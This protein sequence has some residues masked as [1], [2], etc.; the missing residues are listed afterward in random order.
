MKTKHC[1]FLLLPV[2]TLLPISVLAVTPKI[3]IG[4]SHALLLKNDGS[5]WAWGNNGA[6]QLGLGNNTSTATPT[7]VSG[8]TGVVD[9]VAHGSFSMATKADGTVW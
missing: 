2:I 4:Y 9:V 5:V 6:G 1:C 8:L 3:S 7:L